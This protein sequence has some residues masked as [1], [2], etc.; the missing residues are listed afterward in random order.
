MEWIKIGALIKPFGLKGEMKV[1]N[2]SDFAEERYRK[3]NTVYIKLN[4]EMLPLKVASFRM[5]KDAPLVSFVGYQDINLVEKLSKCEIFVKKEELPPLKNGEFYIFQIK[6][7]RVVDEV[8]QEIGVVTQV[9]PT[10][11]NNVIRV[12]TA[13]KEVLIPYV[14]AFIK[15][16][17]LDKQEIIVHVIEGLL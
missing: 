14:P 3:L 2:M 10:G 13:E 16:V 12:K 5:H 1:F 6:G 4:E 11:K 9:E 8:G 15:N 17:D 7:L